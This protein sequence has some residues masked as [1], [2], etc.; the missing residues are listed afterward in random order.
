MKHYIRRH[1]EIDTRTVS[2][3][4]PSVVALLRG[5]MEHIQNVSALMDDIAQQIRDAG[6]W[7]D[8]REKILDVNS[9]HDAMLDTFL[10]NKDFTNS[11]WYIIHRTQ[12]HH[13]I[14]WSDDEDCLNLPTVIESLIDKIEA[15]ASR[16]GKVPS[17][18]RVHELV[19]NL[20]AEK[21]ME[22][23]ENTLLILCDSIEL[24]D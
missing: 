1:P 7:H 10:R 5:N 18:E 22:S 14:D 9:Q 23:I 3:S 24:V 13:R 21:I 8:V 4:F 2:G 15:D 12:P 17:P 11:E 16:Q 19:Q 20:G 6:K